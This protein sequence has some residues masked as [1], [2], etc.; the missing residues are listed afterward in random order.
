MN[1]DR[2]EPYEI[3]EELGAGAFGTGYLARDTVL[4]R[5]AVIKCIPAAVSCRRVTTPR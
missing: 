5:P 4:E 3:V 2:I 1:L